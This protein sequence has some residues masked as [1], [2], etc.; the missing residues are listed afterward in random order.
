MNQV[1]AIHPFPNP[2]WC[3]ECHSK[4]ELAT[5]VHHIYHNELYKH[6]EW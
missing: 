2:R 6:V 1:I 4:R 5:Y 3:D